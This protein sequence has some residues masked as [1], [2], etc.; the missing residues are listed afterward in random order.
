MGFEGVYREMDGKRKEV[1]QTEVGER[2]R[3]IDTNILVE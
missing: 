2:M 1:P 3:N